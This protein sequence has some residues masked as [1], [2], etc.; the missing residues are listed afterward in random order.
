MYRHDT[1]PK[2]HQ[3][4]YYCRRAAMTVY[5]VSV[6][7][8][9]QTSNRVSSRKE[10]SW[11]RGSYEALI[12]LNHDLEDIFSV[13][14]KSNPVR[15]AWLEQSQIMWPSYNWWAQL[16]PKTKTYI[17]LNAGKSMSYSEISVRMWH[18]LEGMVFF[19]SKQKHGMILVEFVLETENM[20]NSYK[21]NRLEK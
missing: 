3:Y 9:N 7:N 5:S 17:S 10:T 6:L 4:C 11:T 18:V 15:H 8:Y 1:E 2:F 19:S 14:D 20:M 16:I 21:P 13:D 12:A